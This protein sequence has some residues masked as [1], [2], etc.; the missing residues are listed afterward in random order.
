MRAQNALQIPS[1]LPFRVLFRFLS[2]QNYVHA[3]SIGFLGIILCTSAGIVQAQTPGTATIG[4][5]GATQDTDSGQ[6]HIV[7]NGGDCT[8]L[9][10]PGDVDATLA[11][12]LVN[13]INNFNC[14]PLVTAAVGGSAIGPGGVPYAVTVH[15]TAKTSGAN[16]NYS[17][18]TSVVSN[19]PG[20]FPTS[21]SVVPF[22]ATLTGGTDAPPPPSG[23][24]APKYVV[25]AVTYAP[26]GSQSNVNYSNSTMMGT[27][28]ATS[29]SF[30]MNTTLS[31]TVGG[32]IFTTDNLFGIGPDGK[33]TATVSSSFAEE[34]DSNSSVTVNTTL[35][36]GTTI[37]GPLSDAAGLD[38]DADIIWLWLNPVMAFSAP[39]PQNLNWLGF[40]FDI[41]DP[42]GEMDVF[43][44][45]VQYLNGHATIPQDIRAVLD[46]TW[47]PPLDDGSSPALNAAD[48]AQIL[49]ADPFADPSYVVNVPAGNNCTADARFC[50]TSNPNLQYSPPPPGFAR[51]AR[52]PPSN[53]DAARLRA[54]TG[55]AT[56]HVV[57]ARTPISA[58]TVSAD[59]HVFHPA[60][61]KNAARTKI[62][63]TATSELTSIQTK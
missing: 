31:V 51:A 56:N 39:A 57:S 37:R 26:P 50:R 36:R 62:G 41:R 59:I 13:S 22:S 28:S 8:V 55:R 24:I 21:F 47:A 35:T 1:H 25:L 40:L 29:D 33:I 52:L 44:V 49:K 2:R 17:L 18:S 53:S 54:S 27:A 63:K 7:V 58:S 42:V 61:L 20:Q 3:W 34:Q 45:Q 16:T 38:H 46:R 15:L 11:Q 6:V 43:G 5:N 32:G 48:F 10:N 9:Y 4:I 60:R 12:T 14:S 19:F 23:F 30:N